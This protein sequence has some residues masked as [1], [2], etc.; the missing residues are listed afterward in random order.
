M[1]QGIIWAGTKAYNLLLSGRCNLDDPHI[2]PPGVRSK[3]GISTAPAITLP[4]H[5]AVHDVIGGRPQGG[6]GLVKC[7]HLRTGGGAKNGSFLWTSF[8]DDP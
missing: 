5:S 1:P 6:V 2:S 4:D 3:C 8:M 7:G